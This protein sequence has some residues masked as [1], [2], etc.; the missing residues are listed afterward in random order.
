MQRRNFLRAA[1]LAVASGAVPAT[2]AMAAQPGA[3]RAPR[4]QLLRADA[5]VAGAAFLPP[6]ARRS[7][8]DARSTVHIDRLHAADGGAVI[9]RL[10]LR[11]IFAQR[12]GGEASFLAWQFGAAPGASCSDRVRFASRG[13]ALRRFEVDYQFDAGAGACS[14][15]CGVAGADAVALPDGQY[16]LIGPRRDG[17]PADAS[18]LVASGDAA[19]PLRLRSRDFDYLAFRIEPSA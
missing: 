19:E 13:D 11:A 17:R 16:V 9:Q 1:T 2:V 8:D 14:E 7:G 6:A 4:L 10:E 15:Q 5:G 12:D 3:A 18:N